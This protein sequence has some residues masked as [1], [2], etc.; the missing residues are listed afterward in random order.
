MKVILLQESWIFGIIL[1]HWIK[2]GGG[3]PLEYISN[4]R[5]SL[6]TRLNSLQI[7]D[8]IVLF[9]FDLKRIA[10]EKIL[11]PNYRLLIYLSISRSLSLSL[12]ISCY[13]IESISV[14][15]R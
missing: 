5:L 15:Y 12:A 7:I 10:I 13:S 1:M 4:D 14:R 8:F 3:A 6:N 9:S 2:Y 11:S